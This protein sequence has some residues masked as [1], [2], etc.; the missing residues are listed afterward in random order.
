MILNFLHRL[1]VKGVREMAAAIRERIWTTRCKS[2]T[3]D[4]HC[5]IALEIGNITPWFFD[6]SIFPVYSGLCRLD[7][8]L[9]TETTPWTCFDANYDY[10]PCAMGKDYIT[11]ATELTGVPDVYDCVLSCHVLEHIA[12]PIKALR[13]WRRVLRPG[14]RLVMLLPRRTLTNDHLRP[15]TTFSHILQDSCLDTSEDDQTHIEEFCRLYDMQMFTGKNRPSNDEI[16]E[17]AT[18]NG[19]TGI[20]H[21]HTWDACLALMAVRHVGFK[22]QSWCHHPPFHIVIVA[23]K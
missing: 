7:R 12:N 16:I 18:R 17:M 21:L 6:G 19:E 22:V 9:K 14:G 3:D 11:C 15:Q 13:A 8:V 20:A 10:Y 4:Y 23:T 1:K 2:F 5:D